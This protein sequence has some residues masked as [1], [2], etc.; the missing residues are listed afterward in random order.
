[1]ER[2]LFRSLRCF[3]FGHGPIVHVSHKGCQVEKVWLFACGRCRLQ[4]WT[5]LATDMRNR[6]AER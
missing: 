1:M 4:I 3:L 5:D 2:C 6:Q